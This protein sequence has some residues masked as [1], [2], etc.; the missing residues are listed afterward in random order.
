MLEENKQRLR[1]Y[2]KSYRE[3]KKQH[4]NFLAFFLYV[5]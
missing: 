5:V 3:A 4:K 1:E 2:Q